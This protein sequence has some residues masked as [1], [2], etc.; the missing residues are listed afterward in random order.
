MDHDSIFKP[1]ARAAVV[2]AF[3][4][5]FSG[6]TPFGELFPSIGGTETAARALR[7]LAL[8]QSTPLRGAPSIQAAILE[9]IAADAALDE[10]VS[11]P[12]RFGRFLTR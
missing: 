9:E 12:S 2:G 4:F 1:L 6:R 3:P 11:F 7:S 10:I 5:F 8:L